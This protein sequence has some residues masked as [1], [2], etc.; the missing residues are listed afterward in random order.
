MIKV[1]TGQL[2][3]E[4][5][6]KLKSAKTNLT[7]AINCLK[8]IKT[9]PKEF[10]K[11]EAQK[12]IEKRITEVIGITQELSEYISQK[13]GDFEEAERKSQEIVSKVRNMMFQV[14]VGGRYEI[15][16]GQMVDKYPGNP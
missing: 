9:I 13:A 11:T 2:R 12:G 15:Q 10:T 3:K 8:S 1:D 16:N 4:A 7:E 6:P 14:E 5:I